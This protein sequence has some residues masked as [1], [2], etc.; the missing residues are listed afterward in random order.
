MVTEIINRVTEQQHVYQQ[1][2]EQMFLQEYVGY[3]YFYA[4]TKRGANL[5][6]S[7]TQSKYTHGTTY[8]HILSAL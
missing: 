5:L 7:F 6:Y 3:F 8:L 2:F 1:L 4:C